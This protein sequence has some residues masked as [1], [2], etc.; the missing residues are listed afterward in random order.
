MLRVL[1]PHGL[2]YINVPSNGDF[3]RYPVDCW[4]F[5]PDSGRALVTWARRNGL[6]PLMLESFVR[7]QHVDL[8]N[9]YVAVF[10]KDEAEA[11]RF[12]RRMVEQI[13]DFTN[14]WVAGSDEILR[15]RAETEDQSN[16]LYRFQLKRRRKKHER[17]SA[18]PTRAG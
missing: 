14:G 18:R 2:L 12:P 7:A 16:P 4:R 8:W 1:K 6:R 17:S 5:Y 3:H 11:G 13:T 9:D 15:P 10:V